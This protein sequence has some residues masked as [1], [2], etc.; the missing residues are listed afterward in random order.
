M[1]Q[2]K[3]QIQDAVFI[4]LIDWDSISQEIFLYS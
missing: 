2:H 3:F 4:V 1:K